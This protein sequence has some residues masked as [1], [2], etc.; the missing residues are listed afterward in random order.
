M[1]PRVVILQEYIPFYR[2]PFF[3]G[4]KLKAEERGID[5]VVAAGQANTR[6]V[7]RSYRADP[8][9]FTPIVQRELRIGQRRINIRWTQAVC[10]G[11]DLIIME[12][13][14]RNI[15]LYGMLL[16]RTPSRPK[17]ALWGHGRDYTKDTVG[18]ESAIQRWMTSRADWFFVYT[19]GGARAVGSDGFA[20]ERITVVQNS[21]DTAKLRADISKIE[22][23]AIDDFER[24]HDLRGKT[25]L[26]LGALDS[27]KR[28]EVL[29]EAA[30]IAH[31]G[32]P[33]FRLLIGGDGPLRA[34]VEKWSTQYPWVCYLGPLRDHDLAISLK[35]SQVVAIPGRIGLAAVD[36]FAA[37]TPIITTEWPWHAPEFEYLRDGENA[38]V[39]ADDIKEYAKRLIEALNDHET[40]ARLG[41]NCIA[42]SETYTIEAMIDNFLVGIEGALVV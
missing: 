32:A 25:A 17:I 8:R 3:T 11:A 1:T 19:E 6:L 24:E 42:D 31:A 12:Q 38:M 15:D 28:L 26:F 37:G 36:S 39:V 14:R 33:D 23:G 16:R 20:A 40:L 22:S 35:A 30:E 2:V 21:T 18:L 13:A 29:K 34:S 9:L 10:R 7:E 27:S 41:R 5:L 4:L